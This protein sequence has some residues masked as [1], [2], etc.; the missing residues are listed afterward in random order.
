MN[1]KRAM[2]RHFLAAIAYRTQR[3]C[4][5]H[6][7]RSEPFVGGRAE[8]LADLS[9]EIVRFHEM[10]ADLAHDLE[11]GRNCMGRPK[12]NYCKARFPMRWLTR[13]SWRCSGAWRV[14]PYDLRTS[15]KRLL[16]RRMSVPRNRPR[17]S[18]SNGHR[19]RSP[20]SEVKETAVVV[21][22]G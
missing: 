20:R 19:L 16:T 14:R 18:S 10:L 4:V 8:P 17:Q 2:L 7:R 22:L 5:T 11:T 12:G 21:V 3:R 9:A 15:W 1:D 6:H 13:D